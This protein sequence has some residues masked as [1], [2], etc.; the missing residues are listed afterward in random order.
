MAPTHGNNFINDSFQIFVITTTQIGLL[1]VLTSV[2]I[3]K[4]D[5]LTSILWKGL[6]REIETN[7]NF[8][9]FDSCL[10]DFVQIAMINEP[11]KFAYS[12]LLNWWNCKNAFENWDWFC[13][14][15]LI[16]NNSVSYCKKFL[17]SASFFRK[18][19]F[20][21]CHAFKLR[22]LYSYVIASTVSCF[23]VP[24]FVR[25]IKVINFTKLWRTKAP[26]Q[27]KLRKRRCD[28]CGKVEAS[29]INCS[30]H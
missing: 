1:R 17:R 10:E 29:E 8:W 25:C 23:C 4:V 6:S 26:V 5:Q 12:I 13:N 18:V 22:R 3:H 28:I 24:F 30:M 21:R 2:K 15:L 11:F 20:A 7:L 14:F 19:F 16:K 27:Q 9:S